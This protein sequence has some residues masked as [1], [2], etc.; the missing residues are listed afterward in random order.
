MLAIGVPEFVVG[1]QSAVFRE[2]DSGAHDSVRRSKGV[3]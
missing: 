1:N 2:H 3:E